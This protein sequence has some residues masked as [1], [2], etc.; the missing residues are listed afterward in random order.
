MSWNFASPLAATATGL[1]FPF[2]AFELPTLSLK[3]SNTQ[4]MGELG[5]R[6]ALPV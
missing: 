1:K 5:V 4:F 3:K 6:L 2:Q